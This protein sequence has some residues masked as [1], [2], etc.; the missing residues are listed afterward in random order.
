MA[1]VPTITVT[2]RAK[3]QNFNLTHPE[4]KEGEEFY[5]NIVSVR[6]DRIKKFKTKRLGVYAF[7]PQGNPVPNL[8]PVFISK[9]EAQ[10]YIREVDSAHPE[11]A[12]L[13]IPQIIFGVYN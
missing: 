2:I 1:R 8:V 9:E 3:H 10:A 7:D 4:L 12:P 6:F 11:P 5:A 13:M